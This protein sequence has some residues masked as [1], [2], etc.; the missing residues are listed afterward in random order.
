ME[1]SRYIDGMGM[2]GGGGA[3]RSFRAA[4]LKFLFNTKERRELS[5]MEL[6]N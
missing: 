4:F 5:Q 6:F 1:G 3:G 2:G